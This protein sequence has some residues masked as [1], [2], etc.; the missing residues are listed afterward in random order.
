VDDLTALALAAGRGERVS[1]EVFVERT[2][3][4]VW[5]L[6]RHLGDPDTADDLTQETYER[7]IKALPRF[8]GD[9]PARAW[10][11]GIARRTCADSVRRRVRRRNLADRL[12]RQADAPIEPDRA[13]ATDLMALLDDLDPDRREAFVLTQLLGLPYAE[14]A[15]AC[16]CPVGTIRSRVARAR[17]DLMAAMGTEG[18]AEATGGA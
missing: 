12:R 13:G 8:R 17:A 11:L 1:L 7:A 9:A 16:G 18:G 4:D 10:L 5:R 6:C 3:A 15:T 2:Q 14:A